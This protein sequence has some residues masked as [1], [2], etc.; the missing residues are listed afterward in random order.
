MAVVV[1]T[2]I[3]QMQ[4]TQ[5]DASR[6]SDVAGFS[7]EV[8]NYESNNNGTLPS[9]SDVPRT[10]SIITFVTAGGTPTTDVASYVNGKN[11]EGVF[12]TRNYSVTILLESGAEYCVGS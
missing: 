6:K 2:A 10:F 7:N 11:C 5:R 9:I 1:L 3:P 12:A 4:R 8:A